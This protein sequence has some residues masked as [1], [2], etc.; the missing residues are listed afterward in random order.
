M[1]PIGKKVVK[2]CGGNRN[3]GAGQLPNHE[4]WDVFAPLGA[5]SYSLNE[6]DK[7]CAEGLKLQPVDGLIDDHNRDRTERAAS[8]R[9]GLFVGD[10]LTLKF[11]LSQTPFTKTSKTLFDE[12][13]ITTPLEPTLWSVTDPSNVDLGE[14]G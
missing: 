2:T 1:N 10:G 12:E 13:Y 4:R 3:S 5:T 8:L 6:A 11:Y 14:R 7:L 9:E